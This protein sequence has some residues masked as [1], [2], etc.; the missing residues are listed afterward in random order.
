MRKRILLLCLLGLLLSIMNL[1]GEQLVFEKQNTQ[2]LL[3]NNS[4]TTIVEDQY[5]FLWLGTELGLVRFDGYSFQIFL[6]DEN[7]VCSIPNNNIRRLIRD[8]KGKIWIA[9]GEGIA[10]VDSQSGKIVRPEFCSA[11]AHLSVNTLKEDSEGNI[12]VGTNNGVYVINDSIDKLQNLTLTIDSDV[13]FNVNFIDTD[14]EQHVWIGSNMG[15][16]IFYHPTTHQIFQTPPALE[17]QSYSYHSVLGFFAIDPQNHLWINDT[18]DTYVLDVEGNHWDREIHVTR[19]TDGKS[20]LFSKEGEVYIGTR[21]GGGLYI[22]Q[23]Q[24]LK[25]SL[26]VHFHIGSSS[27]LDT[28]NSINVFYEDRWGN[29]WA[30]TK[31]GLY[32]RRKLPTNFFHTIRAS[33]VDTNTPSHNALSSFVQNSDGS[34]LVGTNSGIDKFEWLDDAKTT[35]EFSR[36]NRPTDSSYTN[37]NVQCLIESKDK[38]IWIGTKRKI[39]Y[40]EPATDKFY[41]RDETNHFLSE[42]HLS[43]VKVFYED[44]F[45]NIWI[46]FSS[47][48]V[49]VWQHEKKEFRLYEHL[50][51]EDVR[52][53]LKD[54]NGY[55]WIGTRNGLFK[56]KATIHIPAE[57]DVPCQYRHRANAPNSLLDNWVTSLC[58]DSEQTLWVG[59]SSGL[60][61]YD[62]KNDCF[63]KQELPSGNSVPYICGIIE[64]N[65][66]TIWV[67]TTSGLYQIAKGKD[68]QYFELANGYFA[69]VNFAYDTFKDDDGMIYLGGVNGLTYFNPQEIT[70][71]SVAIPVYISYFQSQGNCVDG[72]DKDINQTET[73][74]LDHHGTQFSIEFS[75]LY[76]TNPY[77]I[78]YSYMLEGID[79]DW[80]YSNTRNYVTYSSLNP[81][82]YTFKLRATSPTGFWQDYIRKLEIVIRPPFW[83]TGWAYALYGIVLT[84]I[85]VLL[86]RFFFERERWLRQEEINQWKLKF[87]TNITNGFKI[88]LSLMEVPLQNLL[89]N[90]EDMELSKV[91]NMLEI[92][93]QN[94]KRLSHLTNQLLEFR[95]I[96]QGKV[97]LSLESNDL[98]ALLS[99]VYEAFYPL[100]VQK[101]IKFHLRTDPKSLNV[102][103][104]FE[105]IET[106]LFNLLSNA[107]KFTNKRGEINLSCQLDPDGSKIW[108]VVSDTGIGIDSSYQKKIFERFWQLGDDHS[109]SLKGTG[110]GLSLANDFIRLHK[111]EIYVDSELGKGST[112]R[113]F[114]WMG[115]K[116]FEEEKI[117]SPKVHEKKH[118]E[119][120]TNFIEIEESLTEQDQNLSGVKDN[121]PLLFLIDEDEKH[122]KYV[123][124]ILREDYTVETFSSCTGV[125]NKVASMNPSL[126]ISDIMTSHGEEG[127]KLCKQIKNSIATSHIPIILQI[128]AVSEND[129]L[130]G[131]EMGADGCIEKTVNIKYLRTRIKQLLNTREKIKEKIK[132]DIFVS[133]QYIS[134]TSADEIFFANV[135]QVIEE[136][137]EDENFG[138]DDFAEKMNVSRSVLN[139]KLQS[140]INQTP[141]EF[142]RNIRLKRAAQ[143]LTLG[144]YTVSEVSFK[145]GISAP[146]YFSTIFKKQFGITPTEYAH[147]HAKNKLDVNNEQIKT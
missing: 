37:K 106:V 117:N 32:V 22:P 130:L 14:R 131:Y 84:S 28:S 43:L 9:T 81:G 50:K 115:E 3:P 144:A 33:E 122:L 127:L 66:Q 85:G 45:S 105:K 95:K 35:Y 71:D 1:R 141:I 65:N 76:L 10:Y 72:R 20:I 27:M 139:N 57:N 62:S 82:K 103:F 34:I 98:I 118:A 7:D 51:N 136:N 80:V 101:E 133:P 116:H 140:L 138:L 38:Q 56:M 120:V 46:G 143:L 109:A 75:S 102:I 54:S 55:M 91:Q 93:Q 90:R 99:E 12:W 74:T 39:Y 111:G 25:K 121:H 5:G 86:F 68:I 146:R 26:P 147:L 59:T 36:L 48:G 61:V 2:G 44:N 53:I 134:A 73:I 137:I 52:V 107:F 67:V 8:R 89:K 77:S 42:N 128:G 104:D 113:F 19:N 78:K 16:Y 15:F 79:D 132:M 108:I 83:K 6:S 92:I 24:D 69:S 135:M 123:A 31:S 119:Y 87:Y 145:V 17:S 4:I 30:G 110:I 64:D 23:T 60:C 58:I 21:W 70:P 11:L 112:F 97:S 94:M 100:S 114:L 47:G 88:P 40:Y 96:D 142:V 18:K 29:I 125:F 129:K 63:V 124:D 49:A 126:I 13:D 41:E